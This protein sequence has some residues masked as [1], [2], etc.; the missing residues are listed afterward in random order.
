MVSVF[1]VQGQGVRVPVVGGKV[2][3]NQKGPGQ[4]LF[5]TSFQLSNPTGPTGNSRQCSSISGSSTCNRD[6]SKLR[7][8]Q[9]VQLVDVR[10]PHT[11]GS[12]KH[13]I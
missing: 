11:L 7:S 4:K 3:L 9:F 6:G 13:T 12:P 1:K 5:G 8:P 2:P 10:G